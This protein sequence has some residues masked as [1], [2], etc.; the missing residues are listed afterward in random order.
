MNIKSI[1]VGDLMNRDVKIIDKNTS[2]ISAAKQMM[3]RHVSSFIVM[4]DDP[5]DAFGIITRKDVVETFINSGT[6]DTSILVKDVM[7]K[8]CL[9][10]HSELSVYNCFQMMEMVG[11][12]RMPVTEGS[13]LVGIISNTDILNSIIKGVL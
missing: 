5:H 1:K 4:P 13:K 7:S 9:C 3:E 10:V 6:T 12:R 2:I 8:P 11:V